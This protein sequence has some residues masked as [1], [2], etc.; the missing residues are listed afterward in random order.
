MCVVK[1][2]DD[3]GMVDEESDGYVPEEEGSLRGNLAGKQD[4]YEN[5]GSNHS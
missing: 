4:E 5:R 2:S 3:T 1:H